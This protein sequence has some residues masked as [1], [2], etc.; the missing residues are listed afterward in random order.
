M[1]DEKV[2]LTTTYEYLLQ[3]Y[4]ISLTFQQAAKELG[5]HWQTVRIMCARGDI[6][7]RKA[8]R[9]WVLTTRALATFIDEGPQNKI[10]IPRGNPR[11][12]V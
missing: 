2:T 3:K 7:A 6:P 5:L 1:D 9:K 4:G 8:G 12:I 10:T 11:R